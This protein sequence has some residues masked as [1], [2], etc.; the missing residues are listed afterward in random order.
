M[1]H[2][3]RPERFEWEGVSAAGY[4]ADGELQG[5]GYRGVTRRILSG[6]AGEPATFQVRYFEVEP[7]GYTR[8]ERH[9]H[10]HSVTVVRGSGYA[11]VGNELHQL[12]NLDH[13]YVAP[14]T[15]HQF[16]NDSTEPF[17]FLCIVD[18]QRDRPTAAT[19]DEVRR[20]DASPSTAGKY[21]I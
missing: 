16:V 8:L 18:A 9:D 14:Q 21:R 5:E 19:W 20:L 3:F 1:K 15:I 11:I 17:G 2:K 13:V 10:I 7:G 12:R 4:Q 6:A